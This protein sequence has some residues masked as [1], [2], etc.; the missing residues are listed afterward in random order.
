[1][2]HFCAHSKASLDFLECSF[3]S[4]RS[5]KVGGSLLVKGVGRLLVVVGHVAKGADDHKRRLAQKAS[6]SDCRSLHLNAKRIAVF[7][8]VGLDFLVRVNW[9]PEAT[10][11]TASLWPFASG[12][13][14]KML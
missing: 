9:S 13:V 2:D 8:Y 4:L 10:R 6:V 7:N 1:M 11:P 14:G 5:S 12:S 3:E